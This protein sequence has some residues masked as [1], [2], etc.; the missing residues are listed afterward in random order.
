MEGLKPT[1][2]D[3]RCINIHRGCINEY[4]HGDQKWQGAEKDSSAV[5]QPAAKACCSAAFGKGTLYGVDG[6]DPDA[7]PWAT[8]PSVFLALADP[9]AL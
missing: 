9:V 7:T 5:A 6:A 4:D 3:R 8:R 1:S 2:S